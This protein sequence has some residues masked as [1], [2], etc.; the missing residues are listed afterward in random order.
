MLALRYGDHWLVTPE[1]SARAGEHIGTAIVPF[2]GS[3]ARYAPLA[4]AVGAVAGVFAPRLQAEREI[5]LGKR[6]RLKQ[7]KPYALEE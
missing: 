7:G 1:E 2:L 6:E 5:R 3:M 4:L